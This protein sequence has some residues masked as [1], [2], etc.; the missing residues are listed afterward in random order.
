M[1]RK[2]LSCSAHRAHLVEALGGAHAGLDIQAAHVLPVLL[3]QRHQEINAHLGVHID[4]LILHVDIANGHAHAQHLL[5]LELDGCL[6][7][8]DLCT[9]ST[10]QHLEVVHPPISAM[11][12]CSTKNQ[13]TAMLGEL[14]SGRIEDPVRNLLLTTIR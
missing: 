7:L 1:L 9:A 11:C 13:H 5:Q 10:S 14:D 4:L 12:L 6:D 8:I 3:Q 2:L